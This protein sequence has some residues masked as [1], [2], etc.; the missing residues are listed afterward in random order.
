[1]EE[2]RGKTTVEEEAEGIAIFVEDTG[3]GKILEKGEL[4]DEEGG[5]TAL[6]DEEAVTPGLKEGIVN[7]NPKC[8]R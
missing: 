8:S 2:D 7:D 3:N 1:L 6:E 4:K 5:K